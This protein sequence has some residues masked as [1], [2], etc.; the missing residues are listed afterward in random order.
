MALPSSDTI[1]PFRKGILC[2]LRRTSRAPSAVSG[3]AGMSRSNFTSPL[4]GSML[5]TVDGAI[6]ST[7]ITPTLLSG[8]RGSSHRRVAANC[9]RS[10]IFRSDSTLKTPSGWPSFTTPST[11]MS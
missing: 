1:V 4:D 8:D 7:L 6:M 5:S 11:T 10:W 9:A 3:G 2:A